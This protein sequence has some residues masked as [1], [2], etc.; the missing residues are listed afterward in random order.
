MVDILL[1]TITGIRPKN[2]QVHQMFKHQGNELIPVDELKPG[3]YG[4]IDYYFGGK[5]YTHFGS[6]PIRNLIPRFSVPVY[7]ALFFD[8]EGSDPVECTEIVKRH[9][10]PTPSPVSLD[11]YVPRPHFSISFHRGIHISI[12]IKWVLK[13]KVQGTIQVQ[14]VLGNKTTQSTLGAK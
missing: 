7:K 11:V 8:D 3:E 12:G 6:W 2:F 5:L 9:S 4:H 14:D 13:K 10:G 1:N